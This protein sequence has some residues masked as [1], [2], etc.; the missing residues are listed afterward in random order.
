MKKLIILDRDGVINQD[1]DAFIK[2]E[3][4]CLPIPGS[5]DAIARLSQA[6]YQIAVATNQSGIARGL[7]DE[8]VLARIHQ[9]I[10]RWVE[11]AG[12]EISGFF[13]CPH[14]PDDG[15]DCRKPATGLVESIARELDVDVSRAPFV[16]DSLRDLQAAQAAGC[17]PILVLTGKGQQTLAAGLPAELADVP[18]F[19][20]LAAFATSLTP[21]DRA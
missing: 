14:G 7:F 13:Y 8:Y 18:V 10:T 15:C 6:G 11:E 19:S 9:T 4:E 5:V 21:M 20:D 16:G 2:S 3:Q 12:G 1:S 17:Q